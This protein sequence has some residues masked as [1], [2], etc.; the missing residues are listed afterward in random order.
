M[1]LC[2]VAAPITDDAVPAT[3][4]GL[5]HERLRESRLAPVHIGGVEERHALVEGRVEDRSRAL[6]R[7][8][9][10]A[11]ATEVVAPEADGGDIRNIYQAREIK[12]GLPAFQ[13]GP[14]CYRGLWVVDGAFLMEAAA[15]LGRLDEARN[16]IRSRTLSGAARVARYRPVRPPQ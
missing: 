1:G 15:Y 2:C 4:E 6:D 12:K 3:L 10:R 7:F 16:G 14:T 8:R 13:V 5:A 11:G 9:L